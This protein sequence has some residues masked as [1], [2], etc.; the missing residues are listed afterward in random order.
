MFAKFLILSKTEKI[1]FSFSPYGCFE[2]NLDSP[3]IN[4]VICRLYDA[5]LLYV[6]VSVRLCLDIEKD[7]YII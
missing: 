1:V 6:I 2:E 4:S 7:G 5:E 3:N